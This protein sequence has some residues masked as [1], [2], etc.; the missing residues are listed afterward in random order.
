MNLQFSCVRAF[1]S[2]CP[3]LKVSY[4]GHCINNVKYILSINF[5]DSVYVHQVF[6]NCQFEIKVKRYVWDSVVEI[7]LELLVL[8]KTKKDVLH[9]DR[10]VSRD[11]WLTSIRS[12]FLEDKLDEGGVEVVSNF[13]VLLLLGNELVFESVDF[14]LQFLNGTLSKLSTG[15]GLL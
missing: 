4:R 13:S 5:S 9:L 8:K 11:W 3:Q 10:R 2:D 14:L 1:S 7:V 12:L 15:F 6:P